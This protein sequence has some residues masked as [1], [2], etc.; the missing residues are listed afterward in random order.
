MLSKYVVEEQFCDF[1]SINFVVSW[2]TNKLLTCVIDDIEDGGVTVGW[3]KLFD[4]V[5]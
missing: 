2:D 5:E 1:G 3:Q 4:E